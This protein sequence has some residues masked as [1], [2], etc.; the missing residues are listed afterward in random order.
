MYCNLTQCLLCAEFLDEF[1]TKVFPDDVYKEHEVCLTPE[2]VK[3]IFLLIMEMREGNKN[4]LNLGNGTF[5]AG[6]SDKID[7]QIE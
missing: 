2:E 7:G 3:K 5:L 1:V 4:M 6:Y